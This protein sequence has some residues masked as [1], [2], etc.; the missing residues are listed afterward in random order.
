MVPCEA[1]IFA[2]NF[3]IRGDQGW[4]NG[5]AAHLPVGQHSGIIALEAA[6]DELAHTR[7][8]DPLLPCVQVEDKVIGEGFVLPQEDLGFP[9]SDRGAD[10]TP[11]NFF[12]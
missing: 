11:L 1:Q 10:V 6:L 3:T 5:G 4:A 12:L 9:R 8:I 7:R 2:T